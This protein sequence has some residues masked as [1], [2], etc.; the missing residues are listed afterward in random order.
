MDGE[1]LMTPTAISPP[2]RLDWLLAWP[3]RLDVK[4]MCRIASRTDIPGEE[5]FPF[6][7]LIDI[8]SA[9]FFILHAFLIK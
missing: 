6:Y 2:G 4:E 8:H 5:E 1:I 9:E 7:Y 3:G